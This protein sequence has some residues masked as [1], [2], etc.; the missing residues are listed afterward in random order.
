MNSNRSHT[1]RTSRRVLITGSGPITA[2]GLGIEPLWEAVLEGRTGIRAIERFDASD[3]A[4][5]FAGVLPRDGFDV[6]KIVP[7]SYR[8]ATKVMARDTELAVGAAAVAVSDAGLLTRASEP[9][10][11]PTYPPARTGCHIGAGL[12]AADVDELTLATSTSTTADGEFDIADW[13]ENG[14]GNLTPLWLLKY[15]PN[16]LACHVTIIHD[17]QGPSNTITCAEASS[18]L[19]LGESRRVISRGHADLCLSGGAESKINP[20]GMLRQQFAGRL[21]EVGP[22]V[23]PARIVRPYASDAAGGVL[24]EGGGILVLEA[25]ECARD[26]GIEPIAEFAGFGSSQAMASDSMGLLYDERDR[27]VVDAIGAALRSAGCGPD[28][29]DAIL[30]LG[31]GIPEMDDVDARAIKAVFGDRA[32]RIPLITLVPYI[33]LCGAG[34]GAIAVSLAAQ[35]LREQRL[36]ARIGV[37]DAGAHGLDSG[38]AEARDADLSRVLVFTTSLG[39]QNVAILLERW[40]GDW[41]R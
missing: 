15:L 31:S 28:D 26:R 4:V 12:I 34:L 27:S 24:G 40:K 36:P 23:D 35:C 10:S 19:S 2:F 6:R 14:M 37:E 38:P 11:E 30:P 3:F 22:D 39:G 25:L 8:K 5:P 1:S 41:D 33:G 17:C 9:E 21:A 13:G 7:K 32:A 20:M 18:G 29:V 16:M